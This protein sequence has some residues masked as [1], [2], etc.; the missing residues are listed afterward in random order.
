[1][2]F[3]LERETHLRQECLMQ[4]MRRAKQAVFP[5]LVLWQRVSRKVKLMQGMPN[6]ALFETGRVID[7]YCFGHVQTSSPYR[8]KLPRTWQTAQGIPLF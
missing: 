8:L 6:L 7:C 2:L 1:M 3:I 5:D 4:G